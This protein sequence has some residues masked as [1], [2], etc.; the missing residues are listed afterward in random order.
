[1]LVKIC[2]EYGVSDESED[3]DENRVSDEKKKIVI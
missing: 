3:S 2:V 1:M